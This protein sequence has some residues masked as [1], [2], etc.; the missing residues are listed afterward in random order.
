VLLHQWQVQSIAP[1]ARRLLFA[2]CLETSN[3]LKQGISGSFEKSLY[4]ILL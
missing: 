4:S 3:A 1:F 2:M